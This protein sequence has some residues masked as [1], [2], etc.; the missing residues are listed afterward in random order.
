MAHK[1]TV[2]KDEQLSQNLKAQDVFYW[3]TKEKI[4]FEFNPYK[5][6]GHEYQLDWLLENHK[7]QCFKKAAQMGIPLDINTPIPTVYGWK[8]M[9]AIEIGDEVFGEDGYPRKVTYVSSI[10]F[11][12]DC[13]KIIFS[14]G[15]EII[16]DGNHLWT[17]EDEGHYRYKKVRTITTK[18]ISNTFKVRGHRNRYA[19]KVCKPLNLPDKILSLDPYVLGLWLGDGNRDSLRITAHVDDAIEYGKIFKKRNQGFSIVEDNR[20]ENV[21]RIQ[22]KGYGGHWVRGGGVLRKLNVYKNKHIPYMYLRASYQ[23]RLD[24]LCG[25]MDSDGTVDKNGSCSFAN[26]DKGL[27]DDVYEL[28]MTLGIKAKI[29]FKGMD[30]NGWHGNKRKSKPK[31]IY[32]IYFRVYR[33]TEI[34]K[35]KRKLN[36]LL[37]RKGKRTTETERRRITH[38]EKVKSV[39]VRCISM[40]NPT[41]LYL[42]GKS[43]IPT[44]N[45][46]T[47]IIKKVH[48]MIFGWYPQGVLYLFPTRDDVTDFSKGRFQTIISNNPEAIGRYVQDTDAANIKKIGRAMLYL[49]GARSSHKIEGSKSTSSQ[50]KSVPVDCIVFDEKD[51]MTSEMV[52]LALER[53][54]HSEVQEII[55]ISTP[56]V[57][58]FGI[59]RDYEDS[60]RRVWMIKCEKCNAE[61]CLELTF[62]DCLLETSDGRVIRVCQKCKNEIFSRNGRW[63]AEIPSKSKESIGWWISQ[64]NSTYIEPKVILN[65]FLNPPDG[66]LSEV[67]N[68]KLGMAYVP[69]ENK[70]TRNDVYA[71]CGQDL[72]HPNPLLKTAMGVDVRKNELH[73]VIGYMQATDRYKIIYVGRLPDFNALHDKAKEYRVTSAVIDAEPETYKVRDFQKS[74]P[75]RIF[76]CDYQEKMRVSKRKDEKT[77]IIVQRRTEICDTTHNMVVHDGMLEIPRRNP[78]IEQFALEVCNMVKVLEE[79]EL[80]GDRIYKY[81]KLGDD[82]YRHALNYFHLACQQGSIK[83]QDILQEF[84]DQMAGEDKPYNPF[85]YLKV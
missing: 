19:L 12:Q 60:D 22:I 15:S 49:R 34:F 67:Y 77:G 74:E 61:T 2:S 3:I 50:L 57:P 23:Q 41:H 85:D 63:V 81:R 62:P 69:S 31:P 72:M 68:S 18:E 4:H 53:V 55:S 25:L 9:G 27:I 14:D 58:N 24:L 6:K 39:P 76:L 11:D 82:H 17:L 1:K 21:R 83:H 73:V 59:D 10:H 13:Y 37:D 79:D 29:N 8:L 71:C 42:A 70:L 5:L 43:M 44:H 64:L 38:V 45:S 36:R 56:T 84:K 46:T 26:S 48:R 28:I 54:S 20:Y 66:N 7:K 33:E 75:Y 51:E 47:H 40:D 52:Q 30:T 16:S 35:L 32:Y 65:L 78:E 80:T